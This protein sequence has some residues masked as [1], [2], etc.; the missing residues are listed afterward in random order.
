MAF[1]DTS[2]SR[3]RFLR[4]ASLLFQDICPEQSRFLMR[5]CQA[6]QAPAKTKPVLDGELCPFCFQWR[7]PDNHHIRLR[8]KR[9][10]SARVQ[11]VLRRQGRGRRL[12]RAQ[13]D[14]L[15]RYRASSS[16]L[17]ATCHTCNNTL[18]HTGVNRD[19]M[20]ALS[21]SHTTTPGS[22]G[23]PKTPQSVQ[24]SYSAGTPKYAAKNQTPSGTPRSVAT[25]TSGSSS[26]AS[27]PARPK[28]S[29]FS[30]L[31]RLLVLEDRQ[32]TQSKG[33]LKDFLSS[34]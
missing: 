12:S 20:R 11:S 13:M 29:A 34:L 21:Q 10:A 27:K 1:S 24:K 19:F 31:K 17:M 7:S 2:G 30:R 33:G 32:K 3:Q 25:E 14:I 22:T 26:A 23:K 9:R 8:P 5:S 4:K 6:V 16:V 28:N 15:R 18:R